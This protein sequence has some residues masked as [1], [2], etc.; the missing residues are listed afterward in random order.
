M[1]YK[2][3]LSL[4]SVRITGT[5]TQETFLNKGVYLL[6]CNYNCSCAPGGVMTW[7]ELGV[8]IGTQNGQVIAQKGMINWFG[9]SRNNLFL[10][11]LA[12][13]FTIPSDNTSI[14][15]YISYGTNNS[16][17]SFDNTNPIYG[18][19]NYLHFIKLGG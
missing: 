14:W 6:V 11:Q 3:G 7:L 13:T 16:P 10:G 18:A 4:Q 1:S 9:G 12:N 17:V 2:S 19:L 15:I 8:T 5:V